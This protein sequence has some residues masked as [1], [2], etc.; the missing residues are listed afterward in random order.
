MIEEMIQLEGP[1]T[2]AAFILETV[3][4]TNGI[5]IPPD[6]YMQGVRKLCDKYGILMIA[7]E[8]MA[9]FGRTGEWFAIDHWKVVP[10]LICMAKGLRAS[11][12]PLGA[13]G[14]RRHIAEHFEDKVFY[15]GL[16]YN[17]HP[18]GMRDG[19]GDDS[20]LRRRQSDRERAQ[21]G[22]G[23]ERSWVASCRASIR[24]WARCGRLGCSESSN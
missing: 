2:I 8:V 23:H 6:G 16:T 9:G 21:D 13:V 15:G 14:M 4:G 20:R 3:V 7:D 24:R 22:R 19:A 18:H 12:M 1:Q 5:L 10:D 17:S 11:Y